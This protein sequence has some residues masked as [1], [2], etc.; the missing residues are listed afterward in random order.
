M[1]IYWDDE[2]ITPELE[3]IHRLRDLALRSPLRRGNFL[4]WIGP[5]H[6]PS[7]LPLDS[8]LERDSASPYDLRSPFERLL[9]ADGPAKSSE[10]WRLKLVEP[11][12]TGANGS[13]DWGQVWRARAAKEGDEGGE[14]L[15]V[16]V[17]LY[18]ESLFCDP[19]GRTIPEEGCY[20]RLTASQTEEWE[21]RVYG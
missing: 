4:T 20:A 18:Q 8:Q 7:S 12:Q 10:R 9:G 13:N 6:K 1:S 5:T 17:K 2:E 3:E 11:L 16:V 21:S 14:S 15:S 19:R